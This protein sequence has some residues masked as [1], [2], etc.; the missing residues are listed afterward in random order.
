MLFPATSVRGMIWVPQRTMEFVMRN[1]AFEEL[2]S[3]RQLEMPSEQIMVTGQDPILPT[4]FSL[5]DSTAAIFSAIGV[6]V[7]D[8]WEL[9]TGNRQQLGIDVTH[10]AAT[11]KSFEYLKDHGAATEEAWLARQTRA[12]ISLPHPTRDGRH[13]LPH[14]GM[15]HLAKRILKILDCDYELQAVKKALLQWDALDLENAVAEVNA[16]GAM[17]RSQQEWLSHPHGELM[18]RRPVIEITRIGDSDPVPLS[19]SGKASRPLSG[20]KV[21]DLTRILAGPTCARTLAEHGA[22]VLMVTAEHLPQVDRFVKD[23]SHGKRSCYLD[24]TIADE[25]DKL[26]SL[27]RNADVFSQ[28][29]RPGSMEKLGLAA[30]QLAEIRP[31]II[32]TSMNC[33]GYEGPFK[34]RAGWEQLAQ[35]VTGIAHEHGGDRPSLLPAAACDYS[36]G[37]LAA[38]GTLLALG[39]RARMGGS[40]HV[41]AALCQSA[42]F[43]QRQPRVESGDQELG[44]DVSELEAV[45]Q[46]QQSAHGSIGFL[47]P[48]LTMSETPPRWSIPSPKLGEHNP[49]WS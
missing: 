39:L 2:M 38:Y 5:G 13:F 30:E 8:L 4:R 34:D 25:K 45:L 24:L 40:Y 26:L 42:M 10:A 21:L 17:V 49:V 48:V 36:T 22:D 7:N 23:T 12:G 41:R 20:V 19:D 47:G 31:G 33:Y 11:L 14:M 29:Y 27:V 28:G 15:P 6:A 32:Y 37:Y 46:E 35:T 43:L 44:I 9:R 3:L 1:A 18:V 16:C